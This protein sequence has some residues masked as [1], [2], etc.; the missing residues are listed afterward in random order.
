MLFINWI[1]HNKSESNLYFFN[2]K[3]TIQRLKLFFST[4]LCE[5]VVHSQRL[6]LLT[7]KYWYKK[8]TSTPIKVI[9]QSKHINDRKALFDMMWAI[10]FEQTSQTYYLHVLVWCSNRKNIHR[11]IVRFLKLRIIC[12]YKRQYS[13]DMTWF[14]A[15]RHFQDRPNDRQNFKLNSW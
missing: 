1:R 5:G 6:F 8:L 2:R 3:L 11:S 4:K 15:L 13:L 12:I 10:H 14:P 7:W 9:Y